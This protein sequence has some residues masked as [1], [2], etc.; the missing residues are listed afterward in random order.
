MKVRKTRHPHGM[1]RTF[2]LEELA[3]QLKKTVMKLLKIAIEF[4]TMLKT[5]L[6]LSQKLFLQ[7]LKIQL[8][9]KL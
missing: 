4:K 8:L 3:D 2:G 6:L 7:T 9:L 1:L 5:S